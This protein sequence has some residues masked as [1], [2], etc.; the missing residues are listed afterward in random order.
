MNATM[1]TSDSDI[2]AALRERVFADLRPVR[3]LAEPWKRALVLVPLGLLLLA[4]VHV[5]WGTRS[6]LGGF[7][8]WGLSLLQLAVGVGLVVAALREVIPDRSL[9]TRASFVLFVAGLGLALAVTYL[10]WHAQPPVRASRLYPYWKICFSQTIEIGLPALIAVLALASR[11]LMWR[12]GL[13]GGLAGLAAGLMSDAAWR[14]FCD[15][16][17]PTHVL[18][19]HF[20]GVVVLAILGAVLGKLVASARRV[21]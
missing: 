11:G 17:D 19:A 1:T 3:P 12:A 21:R 7:L 18:S 10:A 14:T 20:A 6:D 2:P 4:L 9:S 5:R 8:L 16:S 15:V 13:V